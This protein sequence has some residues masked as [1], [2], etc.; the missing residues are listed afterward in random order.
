MH[1]GIGYM[2]GCSHGH[3]T[4]GPTPWTSD[5]RTYPLSSNGHQTWGP[6]HLLVTSGGDHWRPVQTYLFGD[7]IPLPHDSWWWQ[8]KFKHIRF[9]VSGMDPTGKL[10]C[11]CCLC[12]FTD[13]LSELTEFIFLS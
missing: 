6:T 11:T 2:V 12:S 8:L 13:H 10:S 5:L 9:Q 1:H 3:K 4:W 7:P